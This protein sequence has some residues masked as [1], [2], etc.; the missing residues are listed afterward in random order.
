MQE[1]IIHNSDGTI[2]I[3]DLTLPV[4]FFQSLEPGYSLPD[5]YIGRH[6]EN[7][8]VN[9]LI[10]SDGAYE[11]DPEFDG[12]LY[13]ARAETYRWADRASRI[14]KFRQVKISERRVTPLRKVDKIGY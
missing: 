1:I 7:G 9:A 3:G 8:R 10:R 13:L 4:A 11:N 12:M 14:Y 6:F 2:L 5:G